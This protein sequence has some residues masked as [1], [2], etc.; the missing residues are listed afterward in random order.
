MKK[1]FTLMLVLCLLCTLVP[2]AGA[3]G[4]GLGDL[5]G[6]FGQGSSGKLPG[7]ITMPD[8]FSITYEYSEDGKYRE[9]TMEKDGNGSYH[10]ADSEDE[11]LFVAEGNGYRMAVKTVNGFAYKNRE[12]YTFDAVRSLTSRFWEC[13][14]PDMEEMAFLGT[15]KEDGTGEVCGRKTDRYLVEVGMSYSFGGYDMSVSEGT[16]YEFDHETGV[17]LAS[18]ASG[19]VNAFGFSVSDDSGDGFAC[20]RF[21]LGDVRLPAVE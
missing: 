19:D 10:Y 16:R 7:K 1:G 14:T 5:L 17:C 11:Y 4:M 18:S 21:E 6:M 20:I 9:V 12:K 3:E 8:R 2:A 13:A 15:V